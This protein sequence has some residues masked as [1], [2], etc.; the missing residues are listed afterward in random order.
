MIRV[1]RKFVFG[2]ISLTLNG[3]RSFGFPALVGLGITCAIGS[4]TCQRPA[5][6]PARPPATRP[7]PVSAKPSSSRPAIPQYGESTVVPSSGGPQTLRVGLSGDGA[8]GRFYERLQTLQQR[9]AARE[10]GSLERAAHALGG[11]RGRRA[12]VSVW[13]DSHIA[14]E[15]LVARLRRR[16]QQTLGDGGPGFVY[17]GRP[18]RSYRQLEVK[19][20]E[21]RRG[22]RS[23]RV[24]SH[25]TRRR[26]PPRDDLLGLGGI[27]VHSTQTAWARVVPRDRKESFAAVDVYYLRQ[28]G[29][30]RLVVQA[31]ARRLR[32]I[33]TVASEKEPGFA[34][35]DLPP[36][37]RRLELLA[38]A[39][40]EVRLYGVD[41]DSGRSGVVVDAFGIN[42]ARA[43]VI[44]RWNEELMTQ[45][46]ARLG[47]D[48][49]V[50]AY[51][52]NEVDAENQ[53]RERFAAGFDESLQ[54]LRR[55]S[56]DAACLVVGPPDQ[57]RYSSEIGR[58]EV[59][60]RL[61]MLVEEQR[62]V[63][64]LRGCAFWDQ[65]AAMGGPGSIFNWVRSDPPLARPDHVH[66]TWEGYRRV[67]DALY[68]ALV[69]GWT[70]HR[71][72][73]TPD[74]PECSGAD[75]VVSSIR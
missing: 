60:A 17:V 44:S 9:R 31:G 51:G 75:R 4:V 61:D 30:G 11:P 5:P 67:A 69:E 73:K 12:R 54:R 23:E 27:T 59:P 24:W 55:A 25:Y 38:G 64:G 46:L 52:S 8:F 14:G 48:L 50:L 56:P 20:T 47:P 1:E 39:A 45:Q 3:M 22:W 34:R 49:I 29:G 70:R 33:M 62:R 32:W 26:P 58:W 65:R 66:L 57:A 6:P 40:G 42:G 16:L 28:P 2:Q 36:R 35:I 74:A 37:T 71:C 21:S 43:E 63:A 19:L 7:A 13:G 72:R 10:P 18:W 68:D 15:A 53:T 41:L